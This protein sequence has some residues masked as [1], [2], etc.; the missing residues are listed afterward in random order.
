MSDKETKDKEELTKNFE[1]IATEKEKVEKE[2]EEKVET[3]ENNEAIEVQAMAQ[4]RRL[5]GRLEPY[6]PGD[7]FDEYL[8]QVDNYFELNNLEANERKVRLLINLIGPAASN[9]VIK[10]FLPDAYHTKTYAEVIAQCKKLF[11]GERNPIVEHYKFNNR[12]QK[13]GESI[14]DFAVDL[15][16]LSETCNFNA[17][18]DTALRDRFVVGLNNVEIKKEL[19]SLDGNSTFC[20]VVD[21]A[22]KEELIRRESKLMTNESPSVNRVESRVQAK[23]NDQKH[24]SRSWRYRSRSRSNSAD[25]ITCYKCGRKGHIAAFCNESREERRTTQHPRG[26]ARQRDR[27]FANAVSDDFENLSLSEDHSDDDSNLLNAVLGNSVG[28]IKTALVELQV[29]S[30]RLKMEVDTGS[31]VTVC[32][33]ETYGQYFAHLK[34]VSNALPLSVVSGERLNVFGS[35]NVRVK[36]KAG[37]FVL[38]LVIIRSSKRFTPLLGR[39]WLEKLIPSWRGQLKINSVKTSSDLDEFRVKVV[40]E[41]KLKYPSVFDNDL[42][43]PIR[44]F[45]VDIKMGHNARPFVHKPYTVPFNLRERVEVQLEQLEKAGIIEK[46]EYAEWAS[47]MVVVAKANKDLRICFDGSVT[48]NPFIETH[49]YPLPV[50]DELLTNKS[51]AKWFCVLDLKGA[52]QQLIVNDKTRKLLAMNTI[53][54]LYA[55]KR[56]PFGVKPAASIFQSVID[57]I[58]EGLRQAQAYIDDILIWGKS[59]RDLYARI[60]EVLARLAEFNVKLNLGK[61]QW[62]VDKVTYLGHIVSAE[63]IAPNNEK[64]RAIVNAP[65]PQ[66]VSQLKA[67][68]G[69]VQYYSKF[70]PKLNVTFAPLYRLLAKDAVWSWD[71]KCQ[72]S[73][74]ACKKALSSANLLAHYD[75]SLPMVITCDASNEGIAGVLSHRINGE[76]RPVMY[77]S[78]SL[79]PAEKNYPILHREALAIVFTLEKLYKYIFG[80]HVEVFTDHKPLEGIFRSKRGAPSVIASRLQRYVWRLSHFDYSVTYKKGVENGNAD[81]LSR[82]PID[83]E[84]SDEDK[85]EMGGSIHTLVPENEKFLSMNEIKLATDVDVILSKVREYVNNGWSCDQDKKLLRAYYAN[86]QLLDVT[87]GVLT[88]D[89]RVVIPRSLQSSVLALLHANHAGIVIM[90]RLARRK[91]FWEGLNQDIERKVNECESCQVLRKDKP[92][93]LY[94]TW[95]E[96]TFPF[97]RIHLDFFHF[98]GNTFLIL[99]DAFSRWMEIKRMNGTNAQMLWRTLLPI[100]QVFGF[101]KEVVTDNGPP[102]GSQELQSFCESHHIKLTHTPPYHP[103]SNG[104]VERA[105]QTAKSVLRKFLYDNDTQFQIDRSLNQFLFNYRNSPHTEDKIIPVTRIFNY[106]PRTALSILSKEPEIINRVAF[107]DQVTTFNDNELKLKPSQ[108]FKPRENVLYISKLKGYCCSLKAK[109]VKKK[110]DTVYVIAI[111]NSVRLA[112]INQLRKSILKKII[113]PRVETRPS[114]TLPRRKQTSEESSDP[115]SPIPTIPNESSDESDDVFKYTTAD[116]ED[117]TIEVNPPTAIRRSARERKEVSRYIPPA[118][119]QRK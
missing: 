24:E 99:V 32:D 70:L 37:E 91:F 81:C 11:V 94:G 71:V 9:K 103:A 35:V 68:L 20:Q 97:E 5:E 116:E 105:V 78:R 65:V 79:K 17:F 111:G 4:Q 16:S 110:S 26:R 101:P 85:N 118:F 44:G 53:K 47:P 56:L 27:N 30:T 57:K 88:F 36:A 63:G 28:S 51:K 75:P 42:T 76:E 55:Y 10:S 38:P 100:F 64:V 52:Y 109:V 66:N 96:T 86:R 21:K 114:T 6:V 58:L 2:E 39:D 112:H 15:Q 1:E 106:T 84:L 31:C 90:K 60:L 77:V 117:T 41:M 72:A 13:E 95:P 29:D 119:R 93:K 80:H 67:L 113:Y 22:K 92:D 14:N 43:K 104:L 61:C 107:N 50:I 7:P 49:H 48:I 8:N 18:L 83:A 62:F 19:L 45:E 98:Q 82:L 69:M 59:L 87:A 54:G 23:P 40:R 89:N 108:I 3:I 115:L 102:F 46:I 25:R 33:Y 73:F 12:Q 74:E 34:I